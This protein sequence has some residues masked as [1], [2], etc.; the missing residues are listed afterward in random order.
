ML[1]A[2]SQTV[3]YAFNAAGDGGFGQSNAVLVSMMRIC[4]AIKVA[5]FRFQLFIYF[6]HILKHKAA[7]CM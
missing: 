7:F 4:D 2:P 6:T 5:S 1:T 3:V